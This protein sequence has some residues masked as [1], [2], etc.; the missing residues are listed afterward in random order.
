MLHRGRHRALIAIAAGGTGGHVFPGLAVA[1]KLLAFGHEVL[2]L[3]TGRG[4]EARVVPGRGLPFVPIEMEGIRGRGLRGWFRAPLL[5]SKA[6]VQARA[7]LTRHHVDAVLGMGGFVSLPVG[8]AARTLG[9]PLIVHEQNRIPGSANR[10]LA[11]L[12]RRVLTG[13]P[14]TPLPRAE[15]VGNPL[16]ATLEKQALKASPRKPHRPL[17]LLIFGGSQGTKIFNEELPL[18]LAPFKDEIEIWHL[19][20]RGSVERVAETYRK[21]G[22]KARV[23]PF[24]EEIFMAYLWA[25]L[26]LCRAG[27]MTVSELVAFGLGAIFIPFPFAV[28]DHQTVNAR[29][30][31]EKGGGIV[32]PQSELGR[33]PELLEELMKAPAK[34]EA[35]GKSA[36]ELAR[37]HAASEVAEKCLI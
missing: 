26:V 30:V 11:R 17:R 23:D 25:D 1:E 5:L 24:L 13:F 32:L 29:Y 20:G 10:L 4:L 36:R 21:F 33:L 28:D 15:W 2:W 8:L 16:R 34:I 31:E 37:L 27:A 7:V 3:G 14:E 9:I 12:A 19:T 18:L 35:M 22:L 6:T